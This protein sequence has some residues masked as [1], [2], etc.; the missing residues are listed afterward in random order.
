MKAGKGGP[1][2]KNFGILGPK[3]KQLINKVKKAADSSLDRVFQS[4]FQ[5]RI[6]VNGS[7]ER[8]DFR[9]NARSLVQ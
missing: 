7:A 6:R 8:C 2:L 3:S 1:M 4:G 9:S 5:H